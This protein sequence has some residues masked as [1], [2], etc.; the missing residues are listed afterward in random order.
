MRCARVTNFE[1][2]LWGPYPA[3]VRKPSG[4]TSGM[5]YEVLSRTQ[6]DRLAPYETDEYCRRICI[7]ELVDEDDSV[8]AQFEGLTFVW[9]GEENEVRM[10][11]LI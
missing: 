2:K 6:F 11:L 9:N 10:V 8:K 7:I 3:L 4:S 5:A 1:T